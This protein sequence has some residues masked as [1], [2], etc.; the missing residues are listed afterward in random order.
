M[1]SI[2]MC[3]II[4][5]ELSGIESNSEIECNKDCNVYKNV[6]FFLAKKRDTKRNY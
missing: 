2:V 3:S 1:S 4:T 5:A 6:L